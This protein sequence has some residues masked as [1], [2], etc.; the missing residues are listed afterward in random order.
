MFTKKERLLFLILGLLLFKV[1][2]FAITFEYPLE[3]AQSEMYKDLSTDVDVISYDEEFDLNNLKNENIKKQIKIGQ[4]FIRPGDKITITFPTEFSSINHLWASSN[5]SFEPELTD[6]Q[7]AKGIKL[8]P[9]TGESKSGWWG[10]S[11]SVHD[12]GPIIPYAKF[13]LPNE[14]LLEGE[15]IEGVLKMNIEYPTHDLMNHF[16]E[17]N[18]EIEYPIVIYIISNDELDSHLPHPAFISIINELED[19]TISFLFDIFRLIF[20]LISSSFVLFIIAAI[21]GEIKFEE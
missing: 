15:T 8:Y 7:I 10:Y 2:I 6:D 12:Y 19:P 16:R 18:K 20:V 13:K 11:I 17:V 3:N 5:V 9:I 14:P 21:F 1:F 4:L